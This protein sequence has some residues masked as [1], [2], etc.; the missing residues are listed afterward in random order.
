LL[1]AM[2]GTAAEQSAAQQRA[3]E[4]GRT[5]YYHQYSPDEFGKTGMTIDAF[6]S[7]LGGD[8]TGF[9]LD[10]YMVRKRNEDAP[11]PWTIDWGINFHYLDGPDTMSVA[12]AGGSTSDGHDTLGLGLLIGATLP[13]TRWAQGEV[14]L[15]PVLPIGGL[16]H[17]T[18]LTAELGLVGNVGNRLYVRGAF[19]AGITGDTGMMFGAGVRL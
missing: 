17:N 3:N 12:T 15:R 11:L 5:Q 13:L 1:L 16:A 10:L 14:R 18:W 19:N 4:T 9:N 2:L 8:V 6:S 7:Q